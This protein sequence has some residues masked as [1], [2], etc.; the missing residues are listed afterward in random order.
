MRY[1]K[2]TGGTNYCGQDF[3]E[4]LETDMTDAELD[5]YCIEAAYE[6]AGQYEYTVW[7]WGVGTAE[8]YAKE[9]DISIEEAEQMIE[10]YYG[11]AYSNWEEITKEEYEE[12][13]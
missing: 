7:G 11:E 6:N 3:E 13:I 1:I 4:Y 8:E 12:N 9:S 10:E 2:I 5:R